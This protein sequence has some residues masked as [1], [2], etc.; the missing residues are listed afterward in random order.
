MTNN[1]IN[2]TKPELPNI[3]E[4]NKYLKI[5]WKNN[6]LTNDGELVRLLE[7]KLKEYL[8]VK[9]LLVVTN[10]TIA[11]QLTLKAFDLKGEIITTPY[12]FAAT[13][14]S[15]L[16][17]G[18]TPVFADI[19]PETFNIDPKDV[20]KKI[21]KNT[22]AILAVHVYGNACDVRELAKI[23][24][25]HNI[26]LIYDAAHAFAVE[27]QNKSLL[28]FGDI[29]TLSFHATKTFHTIE[30]GAIIAKDNKIFEKL[31]LLRDFGIQS[32]EKIVLPGINAK[33]NEFQAAMGLCNLKHLKK[34]NKRR[35]KI[36]KRYKKNLLKTKRIRFQ[37]L[38]VS[39]Y[40]YSYMPVCFKNKKTRDNVYKKLLES[41]IKAR[42][43]FYPLT[44]DF[45]FNKREKLTEKFGLHNAKFV[46]DRIL[47]LPIYPSLKKDDVD[48]ISNII[49]N[50]I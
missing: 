3:D 8:G 45:E 29:S 26:K 47:C 1:M 24:A 42:K 20:E 28:S 14:T 23:A 2:V 21:T 39:K 32:E 44:S 10:G 9:N 13:T 16:W 35:E 12:T 31:K 34:N 33:M 43:Y 48:K 40:N 49:N 7:K 17:E 4:Y 37:S 5:I 11:I 50:N 38:N 46:S 6:W 36:Y 27:Y 30:G 41:N 15:I 25:Q 19:D 22:S 18:L